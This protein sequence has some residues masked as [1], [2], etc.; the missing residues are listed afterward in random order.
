MREPAS[1]ASGPS[2]RSKRSASP[3]RAGADP[4]RV[5]LVTRTRLRERTPCRFALRGGL[6]TAASGHASVVPPCDSLPT[7]LARIRP[8]RPHHWNTANRVSSAGE[9]APR[10]RP[11]VTAAAPKT[12]AE[13]QDTRRPGHPQSRVSLR[14]NKHVSYTMTCMCGIEPVLRAP[15]DGLRRRRA[16]YS[17]GPGH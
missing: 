11:P 1:D 14:P 3:R 10:A 16:L 12:S 9:K 8:Y 7:G 15:D 5:L 2:R 13:D 6:E 17:C 4:S